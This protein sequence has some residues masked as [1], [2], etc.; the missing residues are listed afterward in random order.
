MIS[1]VLIDTGS[2]GTLLSV[3]AV[4]SIGLFPLPEDSLHT[5]R[6]IGGSEVVFSRRIDCLA[7]GDRA[8]N[9][10]EVEIGGMDYGFDI[11]G[12]LG[13]DFLMLAGAV[14]NLSNLTIDFRNS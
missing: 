10:F 2:A 12:I 1:K 7:V 6:G 14:L 3:D 9:G 8:L 4:A 11:N 13:M 5:I